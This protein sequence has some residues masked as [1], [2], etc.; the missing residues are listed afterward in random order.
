MNTIIEK[1]PI[2]P[3]AINF[4]EGELVVL[5]PEKDDKDYARVYE[6]IRTEKFGVI[7]VK[8]ISENPINGDKYS[9]S[10][11]A[12]NSLMGRTFEAKPSLFVPYM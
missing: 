6:V 4:Q 8:I 1:I 7:L 2:N 9:Q 10:H 3:D 5:K 12:G 11:A